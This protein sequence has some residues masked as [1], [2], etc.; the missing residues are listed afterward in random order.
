[1]IEVKNLE[2]SYPGVSGLAVNGVNFNIEPGEIFG[3][4]GPSGAGKSTT[5]KILIKILKPTSGSINIMGKDISEWNNDFYEHIGVGFELP[6]HYSKLSAW[7][8]LQFFS[9][10]YKSKIINIEDLLKRVGLADDMHK[11]TESYSKGMKMR[12]NFVRALM[13]NPNVLFLDEPTSGLDPVN[14]HIVKEIILEQKKAGKTIFLTTHNMHDADELCDRVAFIVDGKLR[15]TDSPDSLK[16]KYGKRNVIVTYGKQSSSIAEFD[17]D[18]L[19]TDKSFIH[20]LKNEFISTIHSQETTLN[21]IF[22][23]TTGKTL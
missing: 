15:L 7:E 4:L 20:L 11:K 22:I 17:M 6:N 19:G 3:F 14:A 16:R 12:L 18:K 23:Q 10:F 2:F 13:H 1:M 8:N 9:S 21:N 5:Q